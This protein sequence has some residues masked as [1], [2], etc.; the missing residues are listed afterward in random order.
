[1][2]NSLIS[3]IVPVYKTAQY[4][5][6]CLDS[7]IRQTYK[8]LEI[9]VVDDGSPDNSYRIC[10]EYAK[11]DDRIKIIQQK[12]SGVSKARNNALNVCSGDYIGFVDSDDFIDEDMYEHLLNLI[13]ENNGDIAICNYTFIDTYGNKEDP[14]VSI[15]NVPNYKVFDTKNATEEIMKIKDNLFV[16]H[17]WDKLFKKDSIKEL[18]FLEDIHCYEDLIFVYEAF[19]KSNSIIFSNESKYSYV[20]SETSISHRD[21]SPKYFT[22]IEA[23]KLLYDDMKIN[24]PD[25]ANIAYKKYIYENMAQASLCVNKSSNIDIDYYLRIIRKNLATNLNKIILTS[26]IS[27]SVKGKCILMCISLRIYKFI[28]SILRRL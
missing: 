5:P 8:N 19:K 15:S 18:F 6:K 16:G 12:N 11:I 27:L 24:Y 23:V 20:L 22:A 10:Q 9:I 7:I 17:V 2:N 21:F 26:E 13:K 25:I 3:I 14:M 4:L 28:L 1:M